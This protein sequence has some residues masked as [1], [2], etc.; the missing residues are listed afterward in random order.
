[1]QRMTLL[2]GRAALLAALSGTLFGT[3]DAAACT[4]A[5]ISARASR[6]GRPLLW[7][8]RDSPSKANHLAHFRGDRYAF[9]GLVDSDDSLQLSVWCGVN[10]AGF[11][12]ANNVSYNLRPDSLEN[13]PY[14]GIVMK[15]A[16]GQCS[17]VEDFERMLRTMPQP[18]GLETNYLVADASGGAA[19]FEVWDYGYERY[20]AGCTPEGYL[21]RTNFS[22]SGRPDEGRGYTR[23]ATVG[24]LMA[25]QSAERFTAEWLLDSAG[26]SFR[27][28]VLG[29]DLMQE[30]LP[31]SGLALDVDHIPRPSTTAGIVIELP[32]AGE[33]ANSSVLWC[34]LGYTPCSYAVAVWVAAGG[35]IPDPLRAV[36]GEP[37]AADATARALQRT[38]FPLERDGGEVYIDLRRLREG[39]LPQVREAEARE[40][41]EGRKLDRK[42]R[43]AGFDA[44][45]VAAYNES[46]DKRFWLYRKRIAKYLER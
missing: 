11:A 34:V 42:L 40:F 29:R 36:A 15:Q 10:E 45:A 17:T 9:T 21:Y 8:Q 44:E 18:N 6:T 27:N 25:A 14:E 5:V 7:K 3:V 2:L 19:C 12:I 37:A 39:I 20:D 35:R 32:A 30:P 38:L 28:A 16:L 43:T 23:Y 26:R 24:E 31:A 46:A 33:A 41:A 13:R 4:T 22:L 1:M